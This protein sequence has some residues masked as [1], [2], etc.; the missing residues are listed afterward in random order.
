MLFD[1]PYLLIE[2]MLLFFSI[3]FLITLLQRRIGS[4]KIREW[5]G[6]N[7]IASAIKGIIIGFITPFCT[8]SA[9]PM[10]VGFRQAGVPPAGYVAFLMAAPVL[11]PVLFGALVIIVGFS[12]AIVYFVIALFAALTLALVAEMVGIESQLK[13]ITTNP[14]LVAESTGGCDGKSSLTPESVEKPWNGLRSEIRNALLSA[15]SLLYSVGP[16]LLV[17]VLVGVGITLL[18]TPEMVTRLIDSHDAYA[19]PIAAAIGTPIYTT[20]ALLI[21]IANSLEGLGL[22]IGAIVALTIAGAG[23]NIPEFILLTKYFKAKLISIFFFY[24]F[25]VAITGGFISQAL[26]NHVF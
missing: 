26:A 20:T 4:R 11:D 14:L 16:I 25:F 3:A 8:Y 13:P 21:P 5:M 9:I 23:A 22:G 2:L 1:T 6:G 17:G 15:T 12:S 18:I 7:P 19:I 24:V 10:L